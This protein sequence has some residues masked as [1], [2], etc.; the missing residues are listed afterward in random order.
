[1]ATKKYFFPYSLF[2]IKDGSGIRFWE[3][4]LLG[5]APRKQYPALYIIICHKGDTVT[6][7]SLTHQMWHSEKI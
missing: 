5:N 7:W 4:K 1:M 3:D 6:N 2:I